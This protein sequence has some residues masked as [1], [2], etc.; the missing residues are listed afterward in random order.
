MTTLL[1]GDC[2]IDA[3]NAPL[4]PIVPLLLRN[5]RTEVIGPL[6]R[7]STSPPSALSG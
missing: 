6:R 5:A 1:S 3:T 7:I 4:N 2:I